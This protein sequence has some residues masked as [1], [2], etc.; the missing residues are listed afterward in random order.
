MSPQHTKWL[1]EM[2]FKVQ[3]WPT[4]AKMERAIDTFVMKKTRPRLR[5]DP[6]RPI[7]QQFIGGM[8]TFRRNRQEP[9]PV[10]CNLERLAASGI[11]MLALVPRDETLHDGPTMATRFRQQLRHAQVELVDDAN[12]LVIIDQTEVVADHLKKF[13]SKGEIL[14]STKQLA[15]IH[16]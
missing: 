16:A 7:A 8:P 13:A 5:A 12:H 2:A 11:P 10:S 14:C 3:R 1:F 4:A 9:R 15:V 6:W